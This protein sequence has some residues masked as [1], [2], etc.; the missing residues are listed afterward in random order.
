[1]SAD[2]IKQYGYCFD[3]SI[4]V[5]DEA[6]PLGNGQLGC[7][8]YGD[9]APLRFTLD[10]VDI[11]DTTPNPATLRDDFKY[12]EL[13]RLVHEGKHNQ[14]E[15]VHRF[16]DIYYYPT[17]TKLPVGRIE[18]VFSENGQQDIGSELD[19]YDAVAQITLKE[20]KIFTYVHSEKAVGII[21]VDGM[22]PQIRLVS[23]RYRDKNYREGT[24]DYEKCFKNELAALNYENA[25]H[26][27]EDCLQ[28]FIQKT[29]CDLIY[30]IVAAEKKTDL[31]C[32]LV[33]TV[34]TNHDGEDWLERA[35]ARVLGQL[36]MD[37]AEQLK[38]HRESWHSFYRSSEI[39]IPDKQL[40]QAWYRNNY[41]LNACS[42][43]GF[44]PMPLQGVW[45]ADNGC[46]PPWKGDYHHD[47][48]TQMSYFSYLKA[49]QLKNGKC[50]VDYLWGLRE[51]GI[52]FTKRFYEC[53]GL[54]YPGVSAIDGTPL[55]GWPQYSLCI[56]TNIWLA[57]A[58]D[59][60]YLYTGD[61]I[62]LEEKAYPF[63]QMVAEA[64]IHWL[65]EDENGK[66]RLPLS[67]SPEVYDNSFEAW[68]KPN[69]ANDLAL[70]IYLFGT[71]KKYSGITN[72]G[73]QEKWQ[74]YLNR[75]DDLPVAEDGTLMMNSE[76]C[77]PES[78]RHLGHL[79]AIYPL[80]LIPYDTPEHRKIVDASIWHL[81]KLGMAYWCAYTYSWLAS[82]YIIQGNGNAAWV[83]LR[84]FV[85]H[86]L[87]PNGFNMNYDLNG[88]R[89]TAWH[90]LPQ[91][92]LESN[93]GYN[94]ALQ[95]MLL[96]THEDAIRVFPALPDCFNGNASFK[97]FRAYYGVIVSAEKI[98]GELRYIELSCDRPIEQAVFNT[99]SSDLLLIKADGKKEIVT[100]PQGNV[101]QVT[102]RQDVRITAVRRD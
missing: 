21:R 45:T 6:I 97:R 1:M 27:R 96:A 47:L 102:F 75:L 77:L 89:L 48:N 11:W 18:L 56:T 40:E 82:L 100:C 74:S 24:S 98:D 54:L 31:G 64:T 10:R 39:E 3:R 7:L 37:E 23:P 99:F 66:L 12:R 42:R 59:L 65:K 101:F 57:Q 91:F 55:G 63:F 53:N 84:Q 8:I 41:F 38:I 50:F 94:D 32:M 46:L 93:F 49:N 15:I 35:K 22:M 51:K 78:H 36:T 81:E 16:D 28:W 19:I 83:R 79:M 17:P 29:K 61:K 68:Q 26:Y 76:T 73:M 14:Q 20:A 34:A 95:E 87:S 85:D 33:Y 90:G 4:K 43:E 13:V 25:E 67:S 30:S 5:W 58:F 92:T 2:Q 62:F 72:D 60:Y 88:S 69:T 70:L 71:L 86:Y 44:Y 80:R 52:E 9:G